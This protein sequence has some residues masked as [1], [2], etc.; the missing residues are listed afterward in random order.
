MSNLVTRMNKR[1]KYLLFQ[2]SRCSPYFFYPYWFDFLL[3]RF[4]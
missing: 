3:F 2:Y 4:R 1:K